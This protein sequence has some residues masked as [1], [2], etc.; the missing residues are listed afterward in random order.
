MKRISRRQGSSR[1]VNKSCSDTE[2]AQG[3]GKERKSKS[4]EKWPLLEGLTVDELARYRR[5]RVQGQPKN[6]LGVD[7]EAESETLVSE[8]REAFRARNEEFL[9]ENTW[10]E[11]NR[12]SEQLQ[13]KESNRENLDEQEK[14]D[15]ELPTTNKDTT[16]TFLTEID[17]DKMITS[18]TANPKHVTDAN[19]FKRSPPIKRD[20]SLECDKEFYADTETYSSYVA[21]E[22]QHRPKLTRRPTSLKMEG[23]LNTTTEKCERYIQWLNVSRPELMRVPTHLKLEGE[24]KTTTENHDKYV[25]FVGVRRP[26]LL[27]QNTNLKLEGESNFTPE[28]ADV[29]KRHESTRECSQ[30]VKPDTYLKTRGSLFQS[31]ENTDN[32]SNTSRGREAQLM[33]ELN[34]DVEKEEKKQKELKEKQKKDEEMKILVGKLEDL[35]GSPLGIPEYKDAYKD[36]PR[37]RPKIVKPEGKIGRADGSKISSSS[38]PKFSTKIDQ[39]PE[40]KSKYLDYQRNYTVHRKS[41]EHGICFTRQDDKRQGRQFISEVRAQY[42]PYGNIPK[43]KTFKMPANLRLEGNL[44][45]EPEYRTAYCA[46]RENQL[47][48]EPK[49]HH[50]RDHCSSVSRRKENYWINNNNAEQFYFT[51]AAKDQ[52]AFQVLNTQVHEDSIHGKP[53]TSSRRGSKS[54]QTQ[55]QRQKQSVMAECDTLKDKSTSPTYRLHVCNVD[56]DSGGFRQKQSPSLQSSRRIHLSPDRVVHSD[57]I[58][59]YSPSFGKNTKQHTNGQSFVVLNNEIFDTSKNET[60]RVRVDRNYNIDGTLPTSKGKTRIP[61]NWMPPWYDSTNTI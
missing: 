29:F 47:Y 43:V 36:F 50:R 24:F 48:T 27:R 61:T 46:K 55:V 9:K 45:L 41:P 37:E 51:N 8:Y 10:L 4:K 33:N 15:M 54:S 20:T 30:P 59:P 42:V 2:L 12:Q 17:N 3:K 11:K 28:Y 44:D 21:Y 32:L 16:E 53:P 13:W 18:E 6:N 7:L 26:I 60:H 57:T 22:G 19:S 1:W 5:K 34:K 56:D 25:P 38:T 58:R 40:Y 23:D 14:K 35:K 31:N 39:D 49:I 52:D